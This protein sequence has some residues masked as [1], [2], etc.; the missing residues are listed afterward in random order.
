MAEEPKEPKEPKEHKEEEHEEHKDH[1]DHAED[2]DWLGLA[3]TSNEVSEEEALRAATED[4]NE[5]V[6]IQAAEAT[7]AGVTLQVL[8]VAGTLAAGKALRSRVVHVQLHADGV[9]QN[10]QHSL[11]QRSFAGGGDS[12]II[13][14]LS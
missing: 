12:A 1:K 13:F 8:Q 2:D 10:L 5:M 4:A 7:V 9:P 14:C 3:V 11:D 6:A